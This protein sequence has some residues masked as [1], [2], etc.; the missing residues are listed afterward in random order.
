[1]ISNEEIERKSRL[2]ILV[3]DDN[4]INQTVAEKILSKIGVLCEIVSDGLLAVDAVENKDYDLILMDLQMPNMN[5]LE[6]T[7]HILGINKNQIVVPMTANVSVED[8]ETCE[9]VG[10]KDFL[11]KPII[12]REC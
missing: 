10:M 4:T 8:K 12:I 1:M 11:A 3:V 6:A 5:G 9:K 7:K 2:N